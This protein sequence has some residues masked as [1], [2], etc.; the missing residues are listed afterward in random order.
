LIG[1]PYHILQGGNICAECSAIVKAV[2]SK[3][4]LS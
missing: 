1:N 3:F 4:P 2:M